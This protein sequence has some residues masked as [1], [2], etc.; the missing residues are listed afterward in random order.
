[1]AKGRLGI[2]ACPMLEDELIHSLKE[3]P[4]DKRVIV[5]ETDACGSL[6]RKLEE[7]GVPYDCADEFDLM[8]G[9]VDIDDSRYNVI[10]KMNDLGLHA[11]PVKLKEFVQDELIDMQGR[12]DAVGLYYGMCGNATWDVSRWADEH[13]TYPVAVFRD[14]TGRVCDDCIGVAVGGLEG[15]QRVLKNYT[16]ELLLTPAFATNWIDFLMAGDIGKGIGL[17]E[18][19]GDPEQDIK[20][21][22]VMC[23][24]SAAVQIDTGLEDKAYFDE[25]AKYITDTLGFELHHAPADFAD[26]WPMDNMYA[27]CKELLAERTG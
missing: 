13:L 25:R 21:L 2:I 3:D 17:I 11:E 24:Y 4:E 5:L 16:G 14:R 20:T 10:V 8:N 1:M 27:R 22:L 7:N 12:V 26:P 6:K 9:W 23:G 19:T 15:Y 18:S